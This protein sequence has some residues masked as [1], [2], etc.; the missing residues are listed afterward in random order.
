MLSRFTQLLKDFLTRQNIVPAGRVSLGPPDRAFVGALPPGPSLSIYLA[1]IRENR[2]LRSTERVRDKVDPKQPDIV[3]ESL[4][5]AWIEAH[6]I[7]TAWDTAID[8]N[9]RALREQE[10]LSAVSAVLLEGDPLTPRH[11]YPDPTDAQLL[12]VAVARKDAMTAEAAKVP[13]PPQDEIDEAG[14]KAAKVVRDRIRAR[15]LAPLHLWPEEFWLPGLPFVVLPP[16]GFPKLSEFWTTMGT[17]SIWKPIVYLLAAV[18]IELKRTF[19]FPMVTTLST[20][21]GQTAEGQK[22][23]RDADAR[24]TGKGT[25]RQWFQ[26]GGFVWKPEEKPDGKLVR[27]PVTRAKAMLQMAVDPI[28]D[29]PT[30]PFLL[31]QETRTDDDGKYQFLFSGPLPSKQARFQ[32]LVQAP[33]LRADPL[34]VVLTPATPSPHDVEMQNAD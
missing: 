9:A 29:P 25:D 10:V 4:Y 7:I 5:P 8:Q 13:R 32:V 2:K 20:T 21:I 6:Y 3:T 19:P 16:D 14:E 26:I 31:L 18:P 23:I 33:G 22:L 34:D 15:V 30:S 1:D 24:K 28:A 11:V 27:A 17:G 12:P